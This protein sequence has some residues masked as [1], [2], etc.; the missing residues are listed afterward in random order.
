MAKA[1]QVIIKCPTCGYN[2][3]VLKQG[4]KHQGGEATCKSCD[5]PMAVPRILCLEPVKPAE[6]EAQD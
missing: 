6:G 1:A 4:D 2:A 5:E 3:K